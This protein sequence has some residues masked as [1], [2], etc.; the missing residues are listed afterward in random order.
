[1]DEGSFEE[2]K[3]IYGLIFLFK[4]RQEKDDRPCVQNYDF[5]FASQV[6]PP[7]MRS[8]TAAHRSAKVINNACA[9][10][11]ILS[12]LLNTP[13]LELGKELAEFR[14][15]TSGFSPEVRTDRIASFFTL[16][17]LLPASRPRY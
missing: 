11:A 15:F 16:C 7:I 6:C 4:W 5:F 17:S 8:M 10:Q 13:E 3:P 2:L 9:T 1:M 14:S 12:V